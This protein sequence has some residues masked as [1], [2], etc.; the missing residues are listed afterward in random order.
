MQQRDKAEKKRKDWESE[1]Y[2]QTIKEREEVSVEPSANSV[3]S[4]VFTLFLFPYFSFQT[5]VRSSYI[6]CLESTTSK[7]RANGEGKGASRQSEVILPSN[8]CSLFRASFYSMVRV[9]LLYSPSPYPSLF[10]LMSLAPSLFLE[11]TS[12]SAFFL[13]SLERTS[14]LNGASLSL[15]QNDFSRQMTTHISLCLSLTGTSLL[16]LTTTSLTH[17]TTSLS[18][19]RYFAFS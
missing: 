7:A 11:T 12:L 14:V 13:L 18:R 3:C 19:S 6:H 8:R 9:F 5:N 15:S 16:S 4:F 1:K 17:T 10:S 2:K